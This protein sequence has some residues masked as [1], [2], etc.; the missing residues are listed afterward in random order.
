MSFDIMRTAS[1]R[2]LIAAHRGAFGGN[3]PCNTLASYEIALKQG[4]DVIEV[5]VEMSAD[6]QLFMFHPG[7]E[8]QHLN[9]DG[10]ICNMTAKEVS[11]L[12]Y[13]NFDRDLTQFGIN[14][15]DEVLETFKGHCYINV[16]KFWGHPKEIYEAIKRHN[17]TEQILVKSRPS[18]EVFTVLKELAPELPFLAVV[19]ETHPLHEQLMKAGINYI[20][21]EVLF[22]S[23]ASEVAS[24]DFIERMHRDGK[25]LWVNSIIYDYR[26]QLTAGHSDDT[27]LCQ[28]MELG[29]GWLARRGFDFIQTDWTGMLIEYLEKNNLR[30][31]KCV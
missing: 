5:D 15:F 9:F 22:E 1:E 24:P 27:A 11:E 13:V 21:A 7:K 26:E 10:R 8:L 17:M 19:N 3:I 31:K 6:G 18:E 28:D 12:R 25:L 30:Y 20:G 14:T 16:D 23:D 2:I 29:W 4:A